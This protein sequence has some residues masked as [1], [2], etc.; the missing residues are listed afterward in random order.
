MLVVILA[1]N[2]GRNILLPACFVYSAI[3][4]NNVEL[5][6]ILKDLNL[7]KRVPVD[8]DAVGVYPGAILPSSSDLMNSLATPKVAAM[9]ASWA[10]K[11]SRFLKWARSRAYVP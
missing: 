11:P 1:S 7:A 2:R 4:D 8:Q 3:D 5:V 6:M 9:M 10:V